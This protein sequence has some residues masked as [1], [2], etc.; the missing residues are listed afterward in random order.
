MKRLFSYCQLTPGKVI[1]LMGGQGE[2]WSQEAKYV[3]EGEF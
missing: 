1:T 3:K 2:N